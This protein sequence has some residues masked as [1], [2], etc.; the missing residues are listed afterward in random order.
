[1]EYFTFSEATEAT[2]C[3]P[4]ANVLHPACNEAKVL[5]HPK[6]I[7]KISKCTLKALYLFS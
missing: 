1:M 3:A 5:S 2:C 6:T 4:T 7:N